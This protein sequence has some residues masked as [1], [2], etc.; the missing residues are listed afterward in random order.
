MLFE[1][2]APRSASTRSAISRAALFVNV[3]ARMAPGWTPC[4]RIRYA[5]RC[6][7]ARVLP[8]PAPATMSTGPSVWRTASAWMSLR[9][10]R[11]GDT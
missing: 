1:T 11:S 2:C 10:S 6:V 5:I 7:S 8:D 4:S 9:P 3:M